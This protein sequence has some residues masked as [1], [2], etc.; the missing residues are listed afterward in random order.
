MVK[1]R[2]C[3]HLTEI[4]DRKSGFILC[5]SCGLVLCTNLFQHDSMNRQSFTD[6]SFHSKYSFID[7]CCHRM[8]V[9]DGLISSIIHQFK[10]LRKRK[11]FVKMKDEI[12]AAFCIYDYLKRE[13]IGKSIQHISYY[14]GISPKDILKVESLDW[15][16]P[17]PI[18]LESLIQNNYRLLSLNEEDSKKMIKISKSFQFRDYS[19]ITLAAVIAY[20]YTNIVGKKTTVKEIQSVF[21]VS[22]MSIYR[23][24]KY[25]TSEK[26]NSIL[27]NL[28]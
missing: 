24:K 19:P 14:T 13:N 4:E 10:E 11:C 6:Y 25:V 8:H 28:L 7:E 20:N 27:K 18:T 1:G 16:S 15:R 21:H 23:A 22:H 12:L 17:Y 2:M 26:V 9:P 5:S 3:L